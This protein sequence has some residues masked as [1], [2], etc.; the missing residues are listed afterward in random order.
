MKMLMSINFKAYISLT[1]DFE[2]ARPGMDCAKICGLRRV[3][4]VSGLPFPEV[5]EICLL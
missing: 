3:S 5:S 4:I 2:M 1:H